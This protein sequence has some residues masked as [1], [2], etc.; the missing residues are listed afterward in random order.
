MYKPNTQN[1]V[2]PALQRHAYVFTSVSSKTMSDSSE[3]GSSEFRHNGHS[4]R[5]AWPGSATWR[6]HRPCVFLL[7]LYG[8]GRRVQKGCWQDGAPSW[9]AQD[10]QYGDQADFVW[11]PKGRE[12]IPA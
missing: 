6:E 4:Q 12:I 10:A 5:E 11:G 7:L 9:E 1:E 3:T 8:A 2:H